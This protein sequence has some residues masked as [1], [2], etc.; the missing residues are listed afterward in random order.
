MK[1]FEEFKTRFENGEF[2]EYFK[3]VSSPEDVVELAK[4]LGYDVT[5][6]DIL[7]VELDDDKL[8]MVAGGSKEGSDTTTT[9]NT[10][11]VIGNY[12]TYVD[13]SNQSTTKP[14]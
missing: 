13:M 7:S 4:E 2:D 8:S 12:N 14:V 1:S 6:E 10:T 3:E 11:N 9:N 5:I